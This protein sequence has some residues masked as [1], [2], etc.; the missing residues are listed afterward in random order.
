MNLRVRW[1]PEQRDRLRHLAPSIKRDL[2][3]VTKRLD[4]YWDTHVIRMDTDHER[5]RIEMGNWRVILRPT[6]TPRL[7]EVEHFDLRRDA[8]DNYPRRSR[9]R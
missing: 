4:D 5:Y 8:Y 7:F 6:G 9:R 3:R 1:P 2:T